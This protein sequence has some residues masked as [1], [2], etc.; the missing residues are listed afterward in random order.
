MCD[1]LSLIGVID[2]SKTGFGLLRAQVPHDR[3]KR[4]LITLVQQDELVRY[5][6]HL[7]QG[8]CLGFSP[9]KAFNDPALFVMLHQLN[10]L[11]HQFDYNL[12]PDVTV[13]LERL[14]NVL[15]VLL[16]LL[17]DLPSDQ[18]SN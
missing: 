10:L 1:S 9:G 13:S 5:H 16:I 12:I 2:P 3:L 15:S 7:L 4:V 18:V 11:L 17:R 8:N 14:L 6:T